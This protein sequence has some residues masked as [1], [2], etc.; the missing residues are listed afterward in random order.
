MKNTTALIITLLCLFYSLNNYAQ[1]NAFENPFSKGK[2]LIGGGI[3]FQDSANE[4]I[5]SD[6][7]DY[8]RENSSNGFGIS[9][10]FGFFLRENVAI[11]VKANYSTSNYESETKYASNG[12]SNSR[13]SKDYG[14][15]F[16][17]IRYFTIKNRFGLSLNPTI[18]L[19]RYKAEQL[20]NSFNFDPYDLYNSNSDDSKGIGIS[21]GLNAG[22][23]YAI[24]NKFI[25]ETKLLG[26][27]ARYSEGNTTRKNI[28]G[29]TVYTT[30]DKNNSINLN[31]V[32]TISFDQ[33]FTINY[34][35]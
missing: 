17:L 30:D 32:N 27:S 12:Y 19:T 3:T 13:K 23:Y 20:S 14:V 10:Y 5:P 11:G 25:I 8:Y 18:N 33:V 35:F 4:S 29:D 24:S 28:N 22:L 16:F 6:S 2:K 9:P 1:E 7:S 34:I 31:F 15:G 26:L 21:A